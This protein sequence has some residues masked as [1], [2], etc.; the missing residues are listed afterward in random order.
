M[1]ATF[2]SKLNI[3]ILIAI[4]FAIIS[5]ILRFF[6]V[7][8][9][10]SNHLIFSLLFVDIS[11]NPDGFSFIFNNSRKCVELYDIETEFLI[12]Y[13]GVEYST[14]KQNLD[15]N[16]E[17]DESFWTVFSVL[18]PAMTGIMAGANL[19]GDLENPGKSIGPGTLAAIFTSL[20]VY[21]CLSLL[22]ASTI[23]PHELIHNLSILQDVCYWEYVVTI[24]VWASTI[25][26]ALGAL[27]GG[28]RI[29]QALA[30]DNLFS[31][32]DVFAFGTKKSDEPLYALF[33]TY[34][35]AQ[36]CM[37][38]GDLNAV[39]AIITNFFLLTYFFTNIACFFLKISGAPNFRP[40]FSYFSWHTALLGAIMSLVI[41]FLCDPVYAGISCLI[42]ICV[43][44][45]VLHNAPICD[46]GD[47]KQALIYH[48]VRKYLLTLD[49]RKNH[50]KYWRPSILLILKK[51]DRLNPNA[52]PPSSSSTL[53]NSRADNDGETS[54]YLPN[55]PLLEIA[56]DLKKGGLYIICDILCPSTP[57]G[58][59]QGRTE[60][61]RK[62][63]RVSENSSSDQSQQHYSGISHLSSLSYHTLSQDLWI[64]II[65]KMK[66]KAFSDVIISPT[67]L[68]GVLNELMSSGIGGMRPNTI[69]YEYSEN[70]KEMKKHIIQGN[71]M[72]NLDT[73]SN[74][75]DYYL[76]NLNS[77]KKS[78][79]LFSTI[80]HHNH[81]S[82]TV[83]FDDN[84]EVNQRIMGEIKSL[85]FD[86]NRLKLKSLNSS[87]V[88]TN[89]LHDE[90]S[91]ESESTTGDDHE[92]S[93]GGIELSKNG[94]KNST[95][96]DEHSLS[97]LPSNHHIHTVFFCFFL[98]YLFIIN[99]FIIFLCFF[100]LF[101][102]MDMI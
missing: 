61:R 22:I 52:I 13:T 98:Q 95:T 82:S 42:M 11:A 43:F 70:I 34:L 69:I 17:D 31:F 63:S 47:F 96:S 39:A 41:M 67:Y 25:S 102:R 58:E 76:S 4:I 92:E 55:L 72:K 14:L 100:F 45:Y 89:P 79:N 10:F 48:Q 1:G 71:S 44:F 87:S 99:R 65:E 94:N 91:L 53:A 19:S 80:G 37:M 49:V 35:I 59:D 33:L 84:K 90:L 9:F 50:P 30:R 86:L 75:S 2:F 57:L 68:N 32:L 54:S 21:G 20:V 8:I 97:T 62:L 7:F 101:C 23:Q 28:A 78:K 5:T 29:L 56:N 18:F 64:E 85:F 36:G 24:G 26:S 83:S 77:N 38:L 51:N 66:I 46:W 60:G 12:R 16:Y 40:L 74:N 3:Y 6:I 15:A 88:T 27:I 73:T 81:D 93:K